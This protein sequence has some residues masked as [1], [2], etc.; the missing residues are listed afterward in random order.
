MAV[1]SA[2]VAWWCTL[3][4]R[5]FGQNADQRS[6]RITPQ[7]GQAQ[8]RPQ[9]HM[10]NA[11]HRS[12][13]GEIQRDPE[14][15]YRQE[16]TEAIASWSCKGEVR[17]TG[18]R[19]RDDAENAVGRCG[20][21]WAHDAETGS[22]RADPSPLK[23]PTAVSSAATANSA[24]PNGDAFQNHMLLPRLK[25]YSA[26]RSGRFPGTVALTYLRVRGERPRRRGE[27][28]TPLTAACPFI[29][30]VAGSSPGLRQTINRS[31]RSHDG[32]LETG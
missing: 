27:G 16:H 31:D 32:G 30:H 12:L 6:S 10:E 4:N 13:C 7:K 20:V 25:L 28:R 23:K 18:D 2:G 1:G 5:G 8:P 29:D 9:I 11:R 24:R 17:W 22:S 3:S 19:H 15:R 26:R 21:Q 14:V